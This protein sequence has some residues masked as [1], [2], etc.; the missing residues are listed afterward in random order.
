MSG[1]RRSPGLDL[2]RIVGLIA[3]V[4]GHVWTDAEVV[5]LLYPWHVPLFFFLAGWLWRAHR[6]FSSEL[7]ARWRSLL[8]PY[9]AWLCVVGLVWCTRLLG[10]GTLAVGDV[11]RPVLGGQY[12]GRP[13]SAFWFVTALAG[14]T[15]LVRSLQGRPAWTR[16][17]L[18]L[19]AVAVAVVFPGVVRLPPL[20]LGTAVACSVF[21]S[22]GIVARRWSTARGRPV[23]VGTLLLLA[24]GSAV[25]LGARPLDLKQADFG[26]PVISVMVAIVICTG[27][28]MVGG[29]LDRLVP[30]RA[31]VLVS[32]LAAVGIG[33]VLVH[34]LVLW[35]LPPQLPS[36]AA[37]CVALCG[38]WS[39]ALLLA[40]TPLAPAFLGLEPIRRGG[41]RAR[42]E[43]PG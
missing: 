29:A 37:F 21:L 40:R 20:S 38:S 30:R 23:L 33:V 1:T 11:V 7:S 25:L 22:A 12:I 41:R 34:A 16:W 42:G 19:L 6:P 13:F 15:L 5:R 14:S 28:V 8:R 2:V 27:L 10:D 9:V 43:G 26:T 17:T 39:V 3:V 35:L 18:A 31:A 4:A 24:G 32:D 36:W